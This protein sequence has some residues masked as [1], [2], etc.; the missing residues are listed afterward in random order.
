[1]G[2]VRLSVYIEN[3]DP[4]DIWLREAE[5]K[6]LGNK[7]RRVDTLSKDQLVELTESL[8]VFKMDVE[9]HSHEMECCESMAGKFMESA[10][11]RQ[12]GLL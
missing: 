6:L 8:K 2:R 12:L 1:M 5:S 7:W 10:K 9:M 4:F 11:V 3:R